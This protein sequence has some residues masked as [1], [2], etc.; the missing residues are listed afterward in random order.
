M[1]QKVNEQLNKQI[2]H[3]KVSHKVS[4]KKSVTEKRRN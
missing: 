3:L 2:E 4:E 1:S